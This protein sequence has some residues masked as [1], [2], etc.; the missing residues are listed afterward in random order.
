MDLGL[1]EVG[2]EGVLE[3]NNNW[4]EGDMDMINDIQDRSMILINIV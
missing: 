2:E 1:H 4:I 3:R